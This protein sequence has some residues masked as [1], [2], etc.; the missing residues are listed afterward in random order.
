MENGNT[1]KDEIE[2]EEIPEEYEEEFIPGT[3]REEPLGK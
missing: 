2:I 3:G 1:E